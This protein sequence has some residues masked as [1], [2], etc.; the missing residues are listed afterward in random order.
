MSKRGAAGELNP[1]T[2]DF[3][4]GGPIGGGLMSLSLPFVVLVLNTLCSSTSCSVDQLP[5]IVSLVV[6]QVQEA[7][8]L[9]P[10]ALGIEIT[11]LVFHSLFYLAPIGQRVTGLVLRNGKSL[12]YNMNAI[13]AFVFCHVLALALEF[14]GVIQLSSLADLFVP[15]M[16][17]AIII[18]YTI[19]VALYLAS[20]RSSSVLLAVGGNSGNP[21][22]DFWIGR[23]LNPRLGDLDLKFMFELRP[24]LIGWSLLNWSFV[25]KAH[26]SGVLTPA[27]VIVAL[28]ESWYVADGLL[29]EEGNLTMMDIVYD[30]FGFML[31][32]GDLAWVPF[33]YTLKCKFLVYH[34]Q[35]LPPSYL[36]LCVAMH[37]VGYVVFRGANSD[38][39]RFRK[40]PKDP[41]VAHLKVMK[42][43]A[44]KSLIISGYWGICRHPNY[45]GDWLMTT[46][47][48]AL[49]GTDFLFPYFQSVY[50][51][52][53]LIHRQLR[54]E[55]Q[56]QLKYGE[57]DWKRFCGEVRYR[58]IPYIY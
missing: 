7:L 44:G 49:A 18:S 24:G 19:S 58:L 51:A 54:D 8:P 1:K 43:S 4:W 34:P 10:F 15:L 5:N 33:I 21:F 9:V 29:I 11:W 50:F 6:D 12:S 45:V 56:M 26:E 23:E 48:S 17:G 53:L 57:E 25:A 38:K 28:F 22:Y 55:H 52:I 40:N 13:H 46:S 20:Y 35:H 39:D 31:C 36:A 32:F 41:R 14:T 16:L 27:I 37:I 47:W 3:E 2:K 42:T 30:G